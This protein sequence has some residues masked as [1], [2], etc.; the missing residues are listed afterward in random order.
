MSMR[1]I[2][3]LAGD[4]RFARRYFARNKTTTAIVVGVLA[5]GIGAN[6]TIFSALQAEFTRP[7]PAM[8]DDDRLVRL[9]SAE[10]ATPTA[11]WVDRDFTGAEMRAIAARTDLFA[12]VMGYVAHD[13]ALTGPDSAGPHG[14]RAQFVTPN[15]FRRSRHGPGIQHAAR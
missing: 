4:L 6:T 13:V 11:Q 14:V 3:A 9:W 7:A 5:L 8:P 12:A 15:H 10:R 2:D 1:W